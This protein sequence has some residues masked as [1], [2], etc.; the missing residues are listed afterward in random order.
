ML[1]VVGQARYVEGVLHSVVGVDPVCIGGSVC[2]GKPALKMNG[3]RVEGPTPWFESSYWLGLK[4]K[5]LVW[6][7]TTPLL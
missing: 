4:N 6:G 3:A 1:H 7:F 5:Y 2:K